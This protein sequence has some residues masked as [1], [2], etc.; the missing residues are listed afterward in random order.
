MSILTTGMLGK[1]ADNILKYFF[2]FFQRTCNH[3][4]LPIILRRQLALNDKVIFCKKVIAY[5]MDLL[6]AEFAQ[7]VQIVNYTA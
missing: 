3:S 5:I 6:S 7:G 4:F 1:L 2:Y